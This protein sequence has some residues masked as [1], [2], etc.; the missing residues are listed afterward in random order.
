[1]ARQI[2]PESDD[3]PSAP[4]WMV[5]FSDCMNL[6]LTFFVLLVTFSSFS[7]ESRQ[8]I[9]SLGAV[10]R[11]IFPALLSRAGADDNSALLPQE[12]VWA[13]REP[14]YGSEKSTL[15]TPPAGREGALRQSP[16]DTDL[17]DHKVFL[18]P[19]KEIFLGKGVSLS[20]QGRY[21]MASMSLFLKEVPGRVVV[22]ENGVEQENASQYLGLSRAWVVVEYLTTVQNLD[23]KRFSITAETTLANKGSSANQS[24]NN[25]EISARYLEIV[26]LERSLYD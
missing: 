10:F 9:Q 8:S 12:Q 16:E 22:S 14:T 1:M 25:R 11:K 20:P 26:L 15:A 23:K 18:I 13:A 21:I 2:K 6:L 24:E 4:A 7:G 17:R 3:G 5:T 19:S